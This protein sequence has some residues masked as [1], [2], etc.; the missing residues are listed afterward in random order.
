MHFEFKYFESYGVLYF[1]F[2]TFWLSVIIFI[3]SVSHDQHI[4]EIVVSALSMFHRV[5]SIPEKTK[6][7]IAAQ[8]IIQE[9]E[10]IIM[11]TGEMFRSFVISL[12][13]HETSV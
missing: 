13:D 5:R 6:D 12:S 4:F 1:S 8:N 2:I 3:C 11:N 10:I 7:W 9:R